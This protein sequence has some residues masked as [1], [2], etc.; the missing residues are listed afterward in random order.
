MRKLIVVLAAL[1]IIGC[2]PETSPE[3]AV[4]TQP[5]I[6]PTSSATVSLEPTLAATETAAQVTEFPDPASAAWQMV[7]QGFNRPVFVTHAGDGRVFIVEQPGTIRFMIDGVVADTPFLEI[8]DRVKDSGNE[9]GLLGLAFDPAFQQN[10]FFYVNYTGRG[11]T[12]F[13]SRFQITDD[14][15]QAD[16][17]SETVLLTIEQPYANHNGGVI[18]FGPDGYL[19]IGVG[20]GGSAG[21]PQGNAQNL[22]SLLGKV[23]RLDVSG[24]EGYTIPADNPF[25]DGGGRAEIWA[26]GLRNPWR[27]VFDSAS[28]DLFIGDVGQNSWEE[29]N[30][31]PA[32]SPGG[33][34]YGWD[35][36][37]G[38]HAYEAN[39]APGSVLPI[40]EYGHNQGCSVTGGVVVRDPNLP[41]WNGVYLF[42]DYCTGII[43]GILPDGSGGWRTQLLY[44]TGFNISSFGLDANGRVYLTDLNGGV[45]RLAPVQ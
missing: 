7:A 3:V 11:G 25:A 39:S 36:L 10:G 9:Q 16:P 4:T 26:Y 12:T 42:G 31:Q 44:D 27:L 34:N 1:I 22:N 41:Q 30:Y 33:Q 23:L 6:Q 14:P 17:G 45:Y 2:T 19:Y 20:D 29:I 5:S 38:T 15:N 43:W 37:E 21:D 32:G 40:A 24:I 35:Y 8:G 18:A 28:G 13:V